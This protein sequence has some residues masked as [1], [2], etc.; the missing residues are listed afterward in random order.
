MQFDSFTFAAFL[1]LV[2]ILFQLAPSWKLQKLVLLL[3]SYLFYAAWSP[4]LVILIW[5]STLTDFSIARLMQNAASSGRRRAL[6][7]VSLVV[8][9]GLLSYFKYASFL[10]NSFIDLMAQFDVIYVAPE[11][12]IILPIGISFYTFQTL[13]YSIDVYRK[14][15]K[16][17]NSLLDFSLFVT[18][19]PQLVAGP[20]MRAQELL[21][22]F[23]IPRRIRQPQL[24]LGISLL[25]WGLFQKTVLADGLY[26]PLVDEFFNGQAVAN[27]SVSALASWLAIF[28]FS[29]QIYFDFSGYSLCAVGTALIFG[30]SLVDN[31]HSP[32]AALGF[33]DFWRRWHISLSQWL[34][35]YL[36]ISLGG[37]QGSKFL[38]L[39]NLSITMLLG[40]LWHGASWNFVVWGLLHAFLL[41]FENLLRNL[42]VKRPPDFVIIL[43]TFIVVTL[44]WIPFRSPDFSTSIMIVQNLFTPGQFISALSIQQILATLGIALVFS[45]QYWRRN[46][47]LDELIATVP[48]GLQAALLAAVVTTIALTATGDSHA[49]IYFQF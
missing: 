48:S 14:R 15:I 8:N 18:F 17:S 9:L 24:V 37:N 32:Y 13:S 38:T 7:V 34:R 22:Q 46:Q 29:M 31:F 21:P 33:S 10:M 16:A 43:L 40:G 45:Y 11:F 5:I 20:I 36:Y 26:A 3:A 4:P 39:R 1:I 27:M 42:P 19:F 2:G 6:L 41:V 28:S 23:E 12:D 30:F 35:D 49:F 25:A 47:T 44:C